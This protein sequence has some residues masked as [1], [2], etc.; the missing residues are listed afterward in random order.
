MARKE[1]QS[2]LIHGAHIKRNTEGAYNELSFSV[3][4]AAKNAADAE[5][6][7]SPKR[8]RGARFGAIPLF[9]LPGRK[10]L[11]GT[12]KK[13]DVLPLSDSS[14][15][16]SASTSS[17]SRPRIEAPK[18]SY[19]PPV[20]EIARRKSRR[21]LHNGV[22]I[23]AVVLVIGALAAAG[24]SFLFKENELRNDNLSLIQQAAANL[25][26][27]DEV[28]LELD[29]LVSEEMD[30]DSVER[31]NAVLS[32]LPDVVQLLNDAQRATDAAAEQQVSS[33]L[34]SSADKE[35]PSRMQAAIAA[36]RS[37]VEQGEILLTEAIAA[38]QA[39]D[40]MNSAWSDVLKA[41]Q[42]ARDA[43]AA[44]AEAGEEKLTE[45]INLSS[46]AQNLFSSA[47]SQ[48]QNAQFI[49]PQADLAAASEYVSLRIDALS[50]AIAS[51]EALIAFNKEE[52]TAQ[53]DAYNELDARAVELAESLPD[54]PSAPI[55]EVYEENVREA[56]NDYADARDT[57]AT[58]D[59]FLRDYLGE[60]SK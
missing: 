2:K 1:K 60:H 41:D 48:I 12:P 33:A 43:A 21:R 29:S 38:R 50:Y 9:T 47:L 39:A 19:T 44:A 13:D 26:S 11:H 7:R 20:D 36:R 37:M 58:A 15:A 54:D 14:A 4:D 25:T 52:A 22:A 17:V 42:L 51:N 5:A 34:S 23:V 30:S 59:A 35:A 28:L 3:L 18:S 27:A 46:E 56:Q 8:S 6:G 32:S 55:R 57:A 16:A 53:N 31:A 45:S 10:K 49:A 24:V 40:A